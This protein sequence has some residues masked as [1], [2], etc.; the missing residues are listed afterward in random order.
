MNDLEDILMESKGLSFLDRSIA[1]EISQ[2][3]LR[4]RE[5]GKLKIEVEDWSSQWAIDANEIWSSIDRLCDKNLWLMDTAQI[6]GPYI[7]SIQIKS[8]AKAIAKSRKKKTMRAVKET[9]EA[10][11]ASSITFQQAK[12]S[13]VSDMVVNIPRERREDALRSGYAGWLPCD[14]YILNGIGFKVDSAFL[15][16]LEKEH[17]DYCMESAFSEMFRDLAYSPHKPNVK[18]YPYWIKNWLT[19]NKKTLVKKAE[20]VDIAALIESKMDSY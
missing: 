16:V 1:R 17:A 19:R 12:P 11:R 8:A 7:N 10:E 9:S 5:P 15:A 2:L 13:S 6:D 3:M 20:K 14:K 4:S 18:Q